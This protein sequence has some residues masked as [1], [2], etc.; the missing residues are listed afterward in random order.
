MDAPTTALRRTLPPLAAALVLAL[1]S[2]TAAAADTPSRLLADGDRD[3]AVTAA[4]AGPGLPGAL[5]LPNLDDDGRRCAADLR[6]TTSK[7]FK[8]ADLVGCSDASDAVVNGAEDEG[9]LAPLRLDGRADT[10]DDATA[11]VALAGAGA[12]HGRLFART[13][14]GWAPAGALGAAELRDGVDLR[15]EATDVVRDRA[16]WDGTIVVALTVTA[17]GATTT[18]QV[19]F[20]VA[21]LVLQ[22]QTAKAQRILSWQPWP[23]AQDETAAR[24]AR[25]TMRSTVRLLKGPRKNVP[26]FLRRWIGDVDGYV[27]SSKRIQERQQ[28]DRV[29]YRAFSG[30]LRKAVRSAGGLDLRTDP[31]TQLF[32]QDQ[33]EHAYA[34]VPAPGGARVIRFAILTA[35]FAANRT[36]DPKHERVPHTTWPFRTLRGPDAAVVLHHNTTGRDEGYDASGA[37]EA[38]PPV[39]GA[40]NG[41]LLL[42]TSGL[43]EK[44]HTAKLLDGQATQPVVRLDTDW[45]A[46]GHVDE[47]I[48][49]VP[50][51]TPRGWVAV[52]ADP[53]RAMD[54]LRSVPATRRGRTTVV[55]TADRVRGDGR[56]RDPLTVRELLSGPV[57]RD[58]ARAARKIDG[59]LALLRRELGLT[60]ADVVR[61]PV[62]YGRPSGERDL[63]AWTGNIAN[64]VALGDRRFLAARANGPRR[65]GRDVFDAAAEAALKRK[66]VTVTWIDTHPVPHQGLG[67]VHCFTNVQRDIGPATWWATPPA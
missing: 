53:R 31:D 21:P 36:L 66:G 59:Q 25:R 32:V 14:A 6:A 35:P 8:V 7:P 27:A 23:A 48:A 63:T 67:E 17:G 16:A 15:L 65:G 26:N 47:T 22:S 19:A 61:V 33:Y 54:L 29:A 46:V 4:D 60:D 9:D 12:A 45:L 11:T 62:L 43:A 2:A 1:P 50:A 34:S 57:A 51:A 39:P 64:G 55:G 42:A 5:V 41:K 24:V 13:P 56:L 49:F 40:P 20:R 37:L 28:D 10:P 30:A 3:G 38:T 52:V 44:P 18:E 58:S